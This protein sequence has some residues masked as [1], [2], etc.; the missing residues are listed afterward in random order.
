MKATAD[1]PFCHHP[2]RQERKYHQLPASTLLEMARTNVTKRRDEYLESGQVQKSLPRA[3]PYRSWCRHC[4]RVRGASRPHRGRSEA[5]REFSKGRVPTISLDHCFLGSEDMGPDG[6]AIPALE[7]PFLIMC[8]A[9]SEAI[10]FLPVAS[11]AV[12]DYV[13]YCVKSVI[14]ELRHS[15]V[16]I[17]L[18]SDAAPEL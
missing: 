1:V 17:A 18:K 10:Y 11:K 13:V 2:S 12:A 15:E 16:R 9:D 4:R 6:A 14:D 3:C 5:D 8:D 7:N